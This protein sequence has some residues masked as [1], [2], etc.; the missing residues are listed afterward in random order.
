M[1]V[2]EEYDEHVIELKDKYMRARI[3]PCAPEFG[4]YIVYLETDIFKGGEWETEMSFTTDLVA[5]QN[6]QQYMRLLRLVETHL[7]NR[8]LETS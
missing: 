6:F 2:V 4:E 7:A 1:D 3:V 5:K 8:L